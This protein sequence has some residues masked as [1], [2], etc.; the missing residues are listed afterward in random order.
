MNSHLL[1]SDCTS[2]E[3]FQ[4]TSSA[5]RNDPM[6]VSQT[7]FSRLYKVCVY[8]FTFGLIFNWLNLCEY[9]DIN[10][11]TENTDGC[12]HKCN[13]TDGSFA[14]YCNPG[15]QLNADG[16]TCSSKNW[17]ALMFETVP[18]CTIIMITMIIVMITMKCAAMCKMV[19][20]YN[21]A[22]W[23]GIL[24][25]KSI[26]CKYLEKDSITWH[27]GKAVTWDTIIG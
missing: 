9:S 24:I 16:K 4:L 19:N 20:G 27:I 22:Q 13:N 15:Y 2:A 8:L 14:C 5:G 18:R 12:A 7:V 10:E 26:D 6:L 23:T 21:I 3:S 17:L 1:A 25:I 11:C